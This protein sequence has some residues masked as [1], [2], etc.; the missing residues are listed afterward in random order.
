MTDFSDF[1]AQIAEWS[2]RGD[3]SDALVTSFVRMAESKLN[4]ELRVALMIQQD[5]GLIASRC[6]P[7]PDDWLA[8]D[9]VRVQNSNGADGFLPARYKA[10]DHFF[11]QRDKHTWMT[12]TFVGKTMFFGGTPDPVDGTEYKIQALAEDTFT[13]LVAGVP[14]GRIVYTFGAANG[15][16]EGGTVNEDTLYAIA[17]AWFAATAG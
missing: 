4:K 16:P 11:N 1:K 3:W 5:D 13:V 14:V 7:L 12:Y 10:R 17:E 6:A 2:N 8:M 9:L 15:V